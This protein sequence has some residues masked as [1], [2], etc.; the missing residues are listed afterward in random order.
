MTIVTLLGVV[1]LVVTNILGAYEMTRSPFVQ[2]GGLNLPVS[3]I[4]GSI[5][6]LWFLLGVALIIMD[7]KK[8]AYIAYTIE[9]L[10]L[11]GCLRSIIIGQNLTTLPGVFNG[12][13]QLFALWF[14]S[15]QLAKEEKKRIIDQVTGLKNRLGFEDAIREELRKKKTVYLLYIHLNGFS[16]INT[17]LGRSYGDELMKIVAER[18]KKIVGDAGAVYSIGGAEYAVL[19]LDYY[20]HMEIAQEIVKSVEKRIELERRGRVVGCYVSANIGISNNLDRDY[21]VSNLMNKADVAMTFVNLHDAKEQIVEYNDLIKETVDRRRKVEGMVK[22]G[23]KQDYFSLV[24]QPQYMIK[25]KKLKG[26]ECLLRMEL[27]DGTSVGPAEFIPIAESSNLILDVDNYVLDRAMAEFRSTCLATNK[28]MTLSINVSARSF[29]SADFPDN[30]FEIV[31]A[32]DFPPECLEI[33]ITEYFLASS[34]ER[35]VHN[36]SRLKEKGIM[37][38]LDDFG[39]GY[40]SLAE[41]MHLPVDLLKIDKS[42]VDEIEFNHVNKDFV[43][44]VIYLGHLMGCKVITEGVEKENQLAIVKELGCDLVQGFVWGRPLMPDAAEKIVIDSVSR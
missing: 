2:L 28:E 35:T 42:L 9:V 36:I 32:N 13:L 40:T 30:L 27:P 19:L 24:Y 16:D 10:S 38:A 43:Q 5:Q 1:L 25:E 41:L 3:S 14:I 6:A 37:I 7:H 44:T 20:R 21:S 33:E 23:L 18:I 15:R 4:N 11:L 22:E 31:E 12:L 34:M 26:F 29:N 39:T 8:G 17:G